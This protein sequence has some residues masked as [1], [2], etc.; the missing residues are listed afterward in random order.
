MQNQLP[1]KEYLN[2]L[3]DKDGSPSPFF[4]QSVV[5]SLAEERRTSSPRSYF[6]YNRKVRNFHQKFSNYFNLH[7]LFSNCAD[8]LEKLA[9]VEGEYPDL[10]LALNINL[11]KL[12]GDRIKGIRSFLIYYISLE[13]VPPWIEYLVNEQLDRLLSEKDVIRGNIKC[14]VD[15][16]ADIPDKFVV[17]GETYTR[18]YIEYKQS[19]QRF[20]ECLTLYKSYLL[21]GRHQAKQLIEQLYSRTTIEVWRK[22]AE[23]AARNLDLVRIS[24]IHVKEKIRRRGNSHSS[25]DPNSKRN[26]RRKVNEMMKKEEEVRIL[27]ETILRIKSKQAKLFEKRLDAFL[28]LEDTS[29]SK[30]ERRLLFNSILGD[31]Y[32]PEKE[33]DSNIDLNSKE[34]K[35]N[36]ENC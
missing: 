2:F 21:L 9:S 10:G 17:Y 8:F 33:D 16:K 11:Q 31:S 5:G 29:L 7:Y 12:T 32:I 26:Q 35:E 34:E 6:V 28:A 25:S 24:Q 19:S 4:L 27:E 18:R 1:D 3:E 20:I 36:E 22:Q 13:E 23:R 14:K 15:S 30:E